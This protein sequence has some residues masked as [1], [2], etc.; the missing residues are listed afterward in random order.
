MIVVDVPVETGKPAFTR[1]REC[2]DNRANIA[3]VLVR[4][5]AGNRVCLINRQPVFVGKTTADRAGVLYATFVC[6]F[7]SYGEE[8]L[9]LDDRSAEVK[10]EVLV[11]E[12]VTDD[13][14][15]VQ[16]LVRPS[17]FQR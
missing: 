17:S 14:T 8:Q 9:V 15:A 1:L 6:F 4:Q 2:P 16:R 10:T 12:R 5:N 3:S 7:I 11:F 13:R